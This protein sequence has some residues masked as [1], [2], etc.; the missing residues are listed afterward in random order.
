MTDAPFV[1][2]PGP[3]VEPPAPV[4]AQPSDTAAGGVRIGQ[5]YRLVAHLG[6]QPD[7]DPNDQTEI[8]P[9]AGVTVAELEAIRDRHHPLF[10]GQVGV[11]DEIVPAEVDGAGTKD[12][13]H[14]VLDFE[15]RE[16]VN[17]EAGKETPEHRPSGLRRRCSFT[18]AQIAGR[19]MFEPVADGE[20]G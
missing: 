8:A 2:P 18:F 4:D 17:H 6:Y 16:L 19:S 5:K 20:D 11:V 12:E 13:D 1:A 3:V 9:G 15:H 14:V 10:A 7:I